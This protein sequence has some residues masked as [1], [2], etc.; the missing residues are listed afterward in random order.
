MPPSDNNNNNNARAESSSPSGSHLVGQRGVRLESRASWG[1]RGALAAAAAAI[2]T[3]SVA[4]ATKHAA[5]PAEHSGA[6]AV[7]HRNSSRRRCCR[8]P[9][10]SFHG[11]GIARAV[12]NLATN[13]TTD[14][15]TDCLHVCL[16][17]LSG[18]TANNINGPARKVS[19]LALKR[20]IG[21]TFRQLNWR[22][23]LHPAQRP[24]PS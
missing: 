9:T 19:S 1:P 8:W 12:A 17:E 16:A 11:S 21:Q 20:E 15:L 4:R 18:W 23:D 2:A 13:R 24:L 14:R 10:I 3:G 7:P 5:G 6:P 22:Q